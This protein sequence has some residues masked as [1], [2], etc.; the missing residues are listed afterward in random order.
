MARCVTRYMARCVAGKCMARCVA[1]ECMARCVTGACMARCVTRSTWLD[2]WRYF[3]TQGGADRERCTRPQMS[4]RA[5]AT[6]HE[7]NNHK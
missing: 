6:Q 4:R 1:G 5:H 3:C 2:V 7:N